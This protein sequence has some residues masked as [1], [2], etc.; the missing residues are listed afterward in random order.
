MQ[1][2]HIK[3]VS[4]SDTERDFENINDFFQN[5]LNFECHVE[6]DPSKQE[7]EVF[8]QETAGLFN[9]KRKAEEYYCLLVFIMSHGNKVITH[10]PLG[11]FS[12]FYL[13]KFKLKFIQLNFHK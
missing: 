12:G 10:G 8:L 1:T 7:L 4:F 11:V 9:N 6:T 13:A 3:L 5:T 2:V